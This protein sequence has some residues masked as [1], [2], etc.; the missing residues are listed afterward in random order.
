FSIS[1]TFSF[2]P[3]YTP[4]FTPGACGSP[5]TKVKSGNI[6]Q[7]NP[8]GGISVSYVNPG[9]SNTLLLVRIETNSTIV[10]S[11]VT[12]N[13]AGLTKANQNTPFDGGLMQTWYLVNPPVGT[14]NIV[15]TSTD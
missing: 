11:A 13:G 15:I 10:P 3:T 14:F 12:Y 2:S 9:G 7:G 8:G 5:P 1:P 4:T 6:F